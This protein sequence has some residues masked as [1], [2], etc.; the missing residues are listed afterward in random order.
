MR[1]DN[2]EENR[3]SYRQLLFR[4]KE[5]AEY[6]SGIIL[7]HETFHHAT[8]D[9]HLPFPQLLIQA[10][11]RPGIT[12]DRGLIVLGGTDEETITEGEERDIPLAGHE[13]FLFAGV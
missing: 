9:D 7:C 4:T 5:C 3:R 1:I 8:D 13:P 12:V 6:L 10:G 2:N 11:I